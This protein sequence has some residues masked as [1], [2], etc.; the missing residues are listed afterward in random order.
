M[1]R[2]KSMRSKAKR[3]MSEEASDMAA[4]NENGEESE[5]CGGQKNSATIKNEYQRW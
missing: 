1:K 4:E 3:I 5:S 2:E